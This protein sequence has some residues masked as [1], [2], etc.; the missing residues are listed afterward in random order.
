[1]KKLLIALAFIFAVLTIPTVYGL[2]D[3]P[4][5]ET[6]TEAG[7][8]AMDT[9]YSPDGEYIAY[10]DDDGETVYVHKFYK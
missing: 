7:E 4:L 10:C 1:M 2:D 6:L 3:M 9:A 8:I 5:Q